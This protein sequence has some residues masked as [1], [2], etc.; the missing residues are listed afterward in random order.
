[1]M[2]QIARAM[3]PEC[4]E[5]ASRA[6]VEPEQQVAIPVRAAGRPVAAR[7]DSVQSSI[8]YWPKD[9]NS[10]VERSDGTSRSAQSG[11]HFSRR[12]GRRGP[13]SELLPRHAGNF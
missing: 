8:W 3:G 2:P 5:F 1:M 13:D 4:Q 10:L 6:T 12:V 11:A 7:V 9:V